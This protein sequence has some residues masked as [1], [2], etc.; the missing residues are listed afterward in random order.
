[1]VLRFRGKDL[2]ILRSML[3]KEHHV[4]TGWEYVDCFA[5][6]K[7]TLNTHTHMCAHICTTKPASS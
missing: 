3:C 4:N 1:M 2:G 7:Y 6:L 5:Y